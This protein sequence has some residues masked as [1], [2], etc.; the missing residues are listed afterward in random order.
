MVVRLLGDSSGTDEKQLTF[1]QIMAA[2]H[3]LVYLFSDR[4][5]SL[6]CLFWNNFQKQLTFL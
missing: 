5:T 4:R 6:E 3:V 2:S 1:P